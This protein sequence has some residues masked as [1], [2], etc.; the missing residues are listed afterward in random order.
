[1]ITSSAGTASPAALSNSAI[2]TRVRDVVLVRKH[3]RMSSFSSA[4]RACAAPSIGSHEVTRTPS[5]SK[6]T[7]PTVMALFSRDGVATARRGHAGHTQLGETPACGMR[8]AF[9]Q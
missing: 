9:G 2:C 8:S 7:P 5:I 1:M 3:R 6:S 4:L